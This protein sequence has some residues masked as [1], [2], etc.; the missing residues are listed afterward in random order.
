MN[1]GP[2][3]SS[4]RPDLP[5]ASGGPGAFSRATRAPEP[6]GTSAATSTWSSAVRGLRRLTMPVAWLVTFGICAASAFAVRDVVFPQ[7]GKSS[8]PAL[9]EPRRSDD[10]QPSLGVS[11][12][13]NSVDGPQRTDAATTTATTLVTTSSSEAPA[14][15]SSA[16]SGGGKSSTTKAGPGT[17]TP[18]TTVPRSTA[19]STT[20]DDGDSTSTSS[21]VS[22]TS[23]TDPTS[24]GPSTSDAPTTSDV[25]GGTI[26]DTTSGGGSGSGRGG[27]RHDPLP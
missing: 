11:P 12:S 9:W 13:I 18:R 20:V 16:G 2:N 25:T 10:T 22:P 26:P 5:S 4:A 21:S 7:M 1:S 14:P 27:D 3:P 6:V 17:T 19:P 23:S 8:A 24:S 15:A